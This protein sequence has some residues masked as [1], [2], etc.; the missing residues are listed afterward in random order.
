MLVI[1]RFRRARGLPVVLVAVG[2]AV[3]AIG[4]VADV[5]AHFVVAAGSDHVHAAGGDPTGHAAHV[6]GIAGMV[7]VLAGVVM[8]GIRSQRRHAAASQGGSDHDAHR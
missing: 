2:L 7:L 4:G 3:M 8:H 5:V 6:V 1:E